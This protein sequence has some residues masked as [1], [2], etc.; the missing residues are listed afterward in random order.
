[1]LDLHFITENLDTVRANCESR[2]VRVDLDKL[3][4]LARERSELMQQLDGV[5]R[6]RNELNKGAKGGPDP[7]AAEEGRR[8]KTAESE[9]SAKLKTLE[10]SLR[11]IQVQ[12]PNMTH[13]D[14]PVGA[15]DEDNRE[16]RKWG[17]PRKFDFQPLDHVQL[18]ERLRLID[19]DSGNK[20][21]GAKFYYLT[22]EAVFLELALIQYALQKLVKEGF[23]PAITPDLAKLDIL[24]ATGFN[25][26]GQES[27]IYCVEGAE[28]G[29]IATAEITLGGM[30]FDTSTPESKLPILLA[31]LSHCFR[32]EAGTYGRASKG[33]Y[34]VH[35]FT[36]VEMFAFCAPEQS[37]ALLERLVRIEEEIYQGLG[38]AYRV[39][40]C[41]TGD[42]GGA[43]YRKYD[44]EAWMPG[45]SEKGSYGEV[46]SAS[47][48]SDYQARRLGARCKGEKKTRLTHTL[49]GTA[50][51][52]SRAMV[53]ILENY[54]EKDGSVPVPEALRP[55]VAFDRIK[56]K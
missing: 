10:D 9:M 1:L 37:D 6:T 43:A 15:S 3:A 23:T 53:A 39:V 12:V 4:A 38:L 35:Q 32:R 22:N 19:F 47:N 29:L 18:G 25:P 44:V 55:F 52:C 14:A 26:R 49:N 24:A 42:L 16:L 28:L 45:R 41:C 27:N 34:R 13:P 48:C 5:R 8:L 40:E 2:R 46:T 33:L 50:I 11:E 30:Y 31:G 21:T 51:A 56:P 20:A 36:K 17:E 7:A 54:Q